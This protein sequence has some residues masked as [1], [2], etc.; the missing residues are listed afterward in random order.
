MSIPFF[1]SCRPLGGDALSSA[2]SVL[3]NLSTDPAMRKQLGPVCVG[4]FLDIARVVQVGVVGGQGG[5]LIIRRSPST[6]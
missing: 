4:R 3:A 5:V 2:L 1:L 6:A